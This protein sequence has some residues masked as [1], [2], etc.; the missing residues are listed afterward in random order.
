M[1]YADNETVISGVAGATVSRYRFVALQTDGKYDPVTTA[2]FTDG[3]NY[4]DDAVDG[5][6]ITIA[7]PTGAVVIVEAG[8][9]I[10]LGAPVRAGT[11][12]KAF[13]ADTTN[14]VIVGKALE[15]ASDDGSLIA[16]QYLGYR[17]LAS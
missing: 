5:E 14:D 10:T 13:I 9:A 2:T 15:A 8:E 12:G 16:I 3:V 1:A 11:A 4:V 6:A 7:V 17:G